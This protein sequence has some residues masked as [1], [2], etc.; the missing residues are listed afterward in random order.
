MKTVHCF[1]QATDSD[2][3]WAAKRIAEGF[4]IANNMPYT[5]LMLKLRDEPAAFKAAEN[6][7][8]SVRL[9]VWLGLFTAPMI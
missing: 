6:R 1:H 5:S 8:K 7:G 9:R 4:D 2:E 3:P